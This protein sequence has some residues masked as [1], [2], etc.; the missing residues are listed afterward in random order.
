MDIAVPKTKLEYEITFW[1]FVGKQKEVGSQDGQ[2]N[3]K[4]AS[5]MIENYKNAV[6]FIFFMVTITFIYDFL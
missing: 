6:N 5:S 4:S 2:R 1:R 3:D